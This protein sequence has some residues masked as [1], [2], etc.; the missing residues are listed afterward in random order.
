M[1]TKIYRIALREIGIMRRNPMY[2]C[3]MLAFPILVTLFFTTMMNEGQPRE[4]PVGVVDND[5]T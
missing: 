5:D 1:L 4:M 3:C 2:L